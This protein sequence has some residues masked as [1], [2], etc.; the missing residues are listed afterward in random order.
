MNVLVLMSGSSQV[1]REAGY[2]YPKNLAEIAGHPMVHHVL[3]S[4]RHLKDPDTRFI[5]VLPR[6]ENRKHHTGKV[7]Q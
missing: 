1:F 2:G 7:I 3:E 5:C 4:L 6:D